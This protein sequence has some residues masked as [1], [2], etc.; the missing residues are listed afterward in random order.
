MKSLRAFLSR[1]KGN[2]KEAPAPPEAAAAEPIKEEAPSVP[3]PAAAGTIDVR[4]LM[5]DLPLEDLCQT[6]ESYFARLDDWDYLLSKP[7]GFAQ[8][9]PHHLI[10]F[11]TLLQGLRLGP[12][13]AVLDFGAGSC[14]ASR[15]LSQL[16]CR[17]TATDVS[18]TALRIGQE[19]YARL[20]V[21]GN[22]PAPQ[23]RV[24]DGRCIDV[25]DGSMDRIFCFDAF[26][27]VPNPGEVLAEFAR[28]LA[29]GGIAGFAEPGPNHSRSAASQADMKNFTVIE[30]DVM[31]EEIWEQAQAVGFTAIELAVCSVPPFRLSLPQFGD[32]LAGGDACRQYAENTRSFMR[33]HRL[34][35]LFKGPLVL[36]GRQMDGLAATITVTLDRTS[37]APAGTELVARATL[38]NTGTALW[39]TQA[40]AVGSVHLGC[41]LYDEAG[42]LRA[43]DHAR[44]PLE[45]ATGGRPVPPGESVSLEAF[46]PAPPPGRHVLGF[47]LVSAGVCWFAPDKSSE[48]KIPVEIVSI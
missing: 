10:R 39:R 45:G 35:F 17:V 32:F 34:F 1:N 9:V 30:N 14:W 24:F 47:D 11:C 31:I 43:V 44:A 6:A 8:E 5:R 19:L 23:F 18:P 37:G 40:D 26:H 22:P 28:A 12:N 21:I 7:F 48:V 15:I 3:E 36:D 16:G 41:H 27:H 29:P 33:E 42:K 2:E 46:V 38:T 13:M 4:R 25:P 20:P